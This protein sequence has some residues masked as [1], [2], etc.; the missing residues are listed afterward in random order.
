MEQIVTLNFELERP[1]QRFP[2][3]QVERSCFLVAKTTEVSYSG[4]L[5][6]VLLAFATAS[7]DRRMQCK[8]SL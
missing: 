7:N 8:Q 3:F 4:A 5:D 2:R 6:S 1:L